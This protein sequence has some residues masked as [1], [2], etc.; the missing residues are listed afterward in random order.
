MAIQC[1]TPRDTLH[2]DT[3]RRMPTLYAITTRY[4]L[5][6][7]TRRDRKRSVYRV[8]VARNE[9]D[10]FRGHVSTRNERSIMIAVVL[11][12]RFF[13]TIIFSYYLLINKRTARATRVSLRSFKEDILRLRLSLYIE[14]RAKWLAQATLPLKH[15]N[16]RKG[17]VKQWLSN[18]ELTLELSR[19]FTFTWYAIAK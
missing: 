16:I 11:R 13:L 4:N 14:Y 6:V 19:C 10:I 15:S 18:R 12:D 5:S 7:K 3:S 8:W 17:N 1:S 9:Y 2:G